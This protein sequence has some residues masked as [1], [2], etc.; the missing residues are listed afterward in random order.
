MDISVYLVRK[1]VILG[2][3]SRTS[4]FLLCMACVCP[5]PYGSKTSRVYQ[6]HRVSSGPNFLRSAY[7]YPGCRLSS[8]TGS[9]PLEIIP[10]DY[11]LILCGLLTFSN[12]PT[13]PCG[14][15]FLSVGSPLSSPEFSLRG[16]L[17]SSTLTTI[18]FLS[19]ALIRF[20]SYAACGLLMSP[21]IRSA[22]YVTPLVRIV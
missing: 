7:P 4:F 22:L 2:I 3:R 19:T 12:P 9:C 21:L 18:G 6:D 11:Q 5:N 20:L 13:A 10:A 15:R 14:G 1:Q 16:C 17:R 8:F